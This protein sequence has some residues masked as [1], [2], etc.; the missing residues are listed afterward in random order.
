MIGLVKNK[1]VQHHKI[2]VELLGEAPEVAFIWR[3]QWGEGIKRAM[4]EAKQRGHTVYRAWAEPVK[5][6]GQGG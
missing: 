5:K 4:L 6:V 1:D 3:G 2:W